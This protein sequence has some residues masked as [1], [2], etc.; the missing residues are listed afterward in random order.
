ML[1]SDLWFVKKAGINALCQLVRYEEMRSTVL[2]VLINK[3]GD[4]DPR[5]INFLTRELLTFSMHE[6]KCIESLLFEI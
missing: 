2:S 1:V 3:F 5:T 6:F 4:K